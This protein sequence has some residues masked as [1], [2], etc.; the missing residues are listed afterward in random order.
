MRLPNPS[1]VQVWLRHRAHESS[2]TAVAWDNTGQ[3]VFSGDAKGRIVFAVISTGNWAK[4]CLLTF[5]ISEEKSPITGLDVGL[6][7]NDPMSS[8]AAIVCLA[9]SSD[10]A[11][12]FHIEL[13]PSTRFKSSSLQRLGSISMHSPRVNV[14]NPQSIATRPTVCSIHMYAC[15]MVSLLIACSHLLL[16]IINVRRARVGAFGMEGKL[17]LPGVK[18]GCGTF[19]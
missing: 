3:G 13:P 1:F 8:G 5:N 2:V 7:E 6:A 11:T 12:V 19:D 16:C 9:L 17:S 4:H 10:Q 18:V 15:T 14:G